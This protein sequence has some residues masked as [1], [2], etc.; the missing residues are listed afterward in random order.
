MSNSKNSIEQ[1]LTVSIDSAVVGY[2]EGELFL[3]LIK[4]DKSPFKGDWALPGALLSSNSLAYN[5]ALQILK[6][7]AGVEMDFLEQLYTF[8]QL[9]RDPRSRTISI[10]Y[11][12]FVNSH[13]YQISESN[14]TQ[15]S[16]WFKLNNLPKLAFD[17]SQIIQMALQRIRNKIEY[18]PL[19]FELLDQEFTLTDLQRLYE[20]IL[21]RELDK[22]NF[23]K[24]ILSTE[25]VAGTGKKKI[26][27]RNRQ[28][29]LYKFNEKVYKK[30]LKQG[31]NFKIG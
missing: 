16:K 25:I 18:H 21:D 23:R 5:Q 17:H 11:Y 7:K 22:R 6:S 19:G 24:K 12:A 8:D 27:D 28:P 20:I 29:E 31:F 4:R 2:N 3:L 30:M 15:D 9:D 26:G 13:Q 1:K 14:K 10:S